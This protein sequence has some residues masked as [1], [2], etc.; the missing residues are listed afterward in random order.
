MSFKDFSKNTN[1]NNA[2]QNNKTHSP[3]REQS[4]HDVE[5]A[6]DAAREAGLSLEEY[7]KN[8]PQ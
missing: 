2:K 4:K 1:N 6:E 5:F 8:K 7:Q 3:L